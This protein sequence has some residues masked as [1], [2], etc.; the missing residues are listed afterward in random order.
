MRYTSTR[1]VYKNVKKFDHTQFD[2]FCT[3]VYNEV[4]KDGAASVPGV[5]I[6]DVISKI[7]G[8]KGIGEARMTKIREAVE[9]LFTAKAGKEE[10]TE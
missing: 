5:G 1:A 7:A 8:V 3:K 6:E 4:Y 10:S 2:D 9:E